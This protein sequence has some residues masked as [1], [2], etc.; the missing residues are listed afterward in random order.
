MNVFEEQ[1]I[2]VNQ[3]YIAEN[4]NRVI[5]FGY[6]LPLTKTEYLILKAIAKGNNSPI[7]AEQISIQAELGISKEN[8]AFHISG[9]NRKAKSISNRILI[10]NIAKIGY[11]LH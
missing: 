1:Y 2:H 11:F 5:Y 4:E 7:S 9:I 8:V 10:K 3:L 6:K